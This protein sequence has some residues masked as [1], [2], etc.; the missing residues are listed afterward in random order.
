MVISAV[1]IV[2]IV[3]LALAIFAIVTGRNTASMVAVLLLAL[4]VLFSFL[5]QGKVLH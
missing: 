1:M 4:V 3:A 5:Q 2:A